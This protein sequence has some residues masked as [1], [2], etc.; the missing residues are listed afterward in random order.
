MVNMTLSIPEDLYK[1]MM[2]HSELK[3]SDVAR[4]AFE[5]KVKELHWMDEVLKNSKIT[6][7]DAEQIGHKVKANMRQRFSK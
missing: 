2:A 3:W 4:Q 6:E 1:E 7:E 5:K